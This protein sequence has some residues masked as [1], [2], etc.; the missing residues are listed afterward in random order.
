MVDVDLPQDQN[1]DPK[2]AL[3]HLKPWTQYAI[4]VKVITL[5]LGDK[6]IAGA[7]SDIIYI[8]TRPSCKCLLRSVDNVPP[9]CVTFI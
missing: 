2:I 1:N 7:K 6:H 3:L 9:L 4:F 8:R 5:Q